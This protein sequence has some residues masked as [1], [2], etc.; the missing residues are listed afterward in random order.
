[1]SN[2]SA[3]GQLEP[4]YAEEQYETKPV[5]I[6]GYQVVF[7]QWSDGE[8]TRKITREVDGVKDVIEDNDYSYETP[9]EFAT[10]NY[11]EQIL[12]DRANEAAWEQRFDQWLNSLPTEE[13]K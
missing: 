12:E 8:W 9:C 4:K 11:I 6:L 5:E 2:Y 7:T 3:N 10:E 13:G 1:M